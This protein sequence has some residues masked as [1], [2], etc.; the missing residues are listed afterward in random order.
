MAARELRL[1]Y[2]GTVVGFLW[3]VLNPLVI[4][5]VYWFVF[6]VGLKVRPLGD[7]PFIVVFACGMI[8][9]TLLNE[10]IV[11]SVSVITRNVHLV[12]KTVFP[13]ETLPVSELLAGMVGHVAML[14]M[15]GVLLAVHGIRPTWALLQLPY[16]LAGLATLGVGLG[17]AASALNVF[18]PDVGQGTSIVMNIWFWLTPV[19]WDLGMIPDSIRPLFALNPMIYIVDGYRATFIRGEPFW[20][21]PAGA[22]VFWAEALAALLAGGFLFRRLK[23]EF[24]EVL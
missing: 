23:P 4:I 10:T 2:A 20:A 14:A 13:T 11:S 15:L 18:L 17:L 3:S 6:S 9:W 19:V 16:Y 7:V 22:A 8:P 24:A 5:A 1:R 12:K 21:N